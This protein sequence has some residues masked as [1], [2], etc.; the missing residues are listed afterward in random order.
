[1]IISINSGSRA[2]G[3]SH[4]VTNGTKAKPRNKDLIEVIEGDFEFGDYL[5]DNNKYEDSY[6]SLVLGFRGKP[7]KQILLQ[8]YEDFKKHFFVGLNADEYHIDS[9]FHFDTD[10]SHIHIRIPKQNLL[11]NTHLQLYYDKIDRPRKELIQDY[12]SLKYGFEIARET[13]REII[14]EQSY[15]IVNKWRDDED[16][17]SFDFSKKNFKKEAEQQVNSYIKEQLMSGHIDKLDDIKT[18]L[19]EIGLNVERFGKDIKKDFSYVTVSNKTGKMRVRGEFYNEDFFKCTQE[20]RKIQIETNKKSFGNIDKDIR[21]KEVEN[22]LKKEN[23]KRFEVVKKLFKSSRE[24]ASKEHEKLTE[25]NIHNKEEKDVINR[26]IVERN[27]TSRT[28]TIEFFES[29]RATADSLRKHSISNSTKLSEQHEQASKRVRNIIQ[30][31]EINIQQIGKFEQ[32]VSRFTKLREFGRKLTD[33]VR[34]AREYILNTYN[35]FKEKFTSDNKPKLEPIPDTSHLENN[36]SQ[37]Q[38]KQKRKKI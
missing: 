36:Q 17:I 30:E 4:Y 35:D 13:N 28:E 26:A 19:E 31:S 1:M 37:I 18:I 29:L 38:Q 11:T 34:T 32:Q 22:K 16:R 12:I 23:E 8:A 2:K 20:D 24:K 5:C 15:E 6:Y 27:R 33:Y 25:K 7:D 9:I 3:W 21:L 14:K 10:D